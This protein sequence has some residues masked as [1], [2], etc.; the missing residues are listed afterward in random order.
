[1]NRKNNMN[2]RPLFRR[3]RDHRGSTLVEAALVT[4]LVLLLTFSIIEFASLFYAYLALEN[5]VSQAT[6]FAVTGNVMDDPTTP[7]AQL[8]RQESIKAALRQATP[9]LTISDA[10]LTFSHL[11]TGA[12][13]W[14]NGIGGPDDIEK[15][16]VTYTWTF[17]TPLMRAFFRDGQVTLA[18]ESAMKNEGRFE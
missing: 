7:G 6:R 5:G 3:L 11:P 10:D 18:V 1:M 9:T 14:V 15:L 12:S 8:S 17:F 13:A 4:P 16:G 2:P